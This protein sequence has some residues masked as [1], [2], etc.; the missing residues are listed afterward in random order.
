MPEPTTHNQRVKGTT[1]TCRAEDIV[2][3]ELGL[4]NSQ[5]EAIYG[6]VRTRM[7]HAGILG[8]QMRSIQSKADARRIGTEVQRAHKTVLGKIESAV[9]DV[10]ILRIAQRINSN[11]RRAQ[12]RRARGPRMPDGEHSDPPAIPDTKHS[13]RNDTPTN[14]TT[15]QRTYLTRGYALHSDPRASVSTSS[16]SNGQSP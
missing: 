8:S 3:K 11:A 4:T 16:R 7:Q 10:N 9:F 13:T 6:D 15:I 5:Y 2:K 12:R 1:K 14:N